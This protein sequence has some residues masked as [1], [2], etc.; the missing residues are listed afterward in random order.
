MSSLFLRFS[1]LVTITWGL[2]GDLLGATTPSLSSL[3]TCSLMNLQSSLLYRR[4]LVAIGWIFSVRLAKGSSDYILRVL[5]QQFDSGGWVSLHWK[6]MLLCCDCKP[7]RSIRLA[8]G[9][10][11]MERLSLVYFR[12]W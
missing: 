6:V 5:K 12:S 2:Q 7:T 3:S 1:S 11:R 4:D 10:D 9:P 8:Q